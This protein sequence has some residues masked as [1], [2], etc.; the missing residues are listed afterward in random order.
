MF[1]DKMPGHKAVER[2][3]L[4]QFMRGTVCYRVRHYPTRTRRCLETTRSPTAVDEQVFDRGETNDRGGVR[5]N[6][7]DAAQVRNTCAREKIETIQ[8]PL[9]TGVRSHGSRPLCI[10]VEGVGACAHHQLTFVGPG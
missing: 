3:R 10:R 5:R 6:I 7:N 2:K 4:I 8:S 1:V 9:P